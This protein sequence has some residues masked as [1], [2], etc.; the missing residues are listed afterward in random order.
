MSTESEVGLR[1]LRD[2][3]LPQVVVVWV[4]SALC[5]ASVF[6]TAGLYLRTSS[7]VGTLPVT[8]AW[9]SGGISFSAAV[10]V[11]RRA[12]EGW[13][14]VRWGGLGGAEVL[15]G[16]VAERR[17]RIK[18]LPRSAEMVVRFLVAPLATITSSAAMLV[19]VLTSATMEPV[20]SNQGQQSACVTAVLNVRSALD[21]GQRS[22][23]LIEQ[24]NS[25]EID[26]E[27]G[28]ESVIVDD[29]ATS[30][31]SPGVSHHAEF[32]LQGDGRHIV[33]DLDVDAS[34][35]GGDGTPEQLKVTAESVLFEPPV[36]AAVAK[37]SASYGDCYFADGY[38]YAPI[39]LSDLR[40]GQEAC[41]RTSGGRVARLVMVTGSRGDRLRMT[42]WKIG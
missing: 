23:A 16:R 3:W 14:P 2:I 38:A 40:S 11:T 20:S 19:A 15:S 9:I 31:R 39:R 25:P 10:Y 1:R 28:D 17:D 36:E 37:S 22:R 32:P 33:R 4:C 26:E 7:G 35:P 5:L 34:E 8:I 41:L 12:L 30:Q 18:T 27:C 24:I 13:R 42:V 21:A 29:L 6:V